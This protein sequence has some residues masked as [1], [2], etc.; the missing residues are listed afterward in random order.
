MLV[1]AYHATRTGTPVRQ[2]WWDCELA[3]TSDAHSNHPLIP[4]GNNLATAELEAE[5]LSSIPGRI[6]LVTGVPGHAHVMNFCSVTC[7]C[8]LT[9]SRDQVNNP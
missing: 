1:W 6:E 3:S 7:R 8:L 4:T 5:R 9:V 2:S